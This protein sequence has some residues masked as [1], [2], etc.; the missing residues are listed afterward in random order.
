ML[1]DEV[2]VLPRPHQPLLAIAMIDYWHDEVVV[3][4]PV[5]GLAKNRMEE[6]LNK[7]KY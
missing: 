7:Q 1:Y 3:L 2:A 5:S 4:V 6:F